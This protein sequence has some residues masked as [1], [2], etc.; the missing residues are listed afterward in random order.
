MINGFRIFRTQ[1]IMEE[2]RNFYKKKLDKVI[3]N[4]EVMAN[5]KVIDQN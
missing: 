4:D 2:I 1:K 5:N 3:K